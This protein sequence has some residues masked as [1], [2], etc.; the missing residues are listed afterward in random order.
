ML[1]QCHLL[2]ENAPKLPL[3]FYM[4]VIMHV[5]TAGEA[6]SNQC[7]DTGLNN[8]CWRKWSNHALRA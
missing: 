5:G 8:V 7:I 2:W 6:R 1:H 4:M 3:D